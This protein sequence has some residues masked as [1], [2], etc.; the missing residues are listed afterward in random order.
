MRL[1]RGLARVWRAVHLSGLFWLNCIV[2]SVAI[3]EIRD[4]PSQL[5]NVIFITVI[6]IN[7]M[8]ANDVTNRLSLLAP[9]PLG[10]VVLQ[11]LHQ[12]LCYRTLRVGGRRMDGWIR[13]GHHVLWVP[14]PTWYPRALGPPALQTLQIVSLCIKPKNIAFFPSRRKQH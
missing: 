7:W 1:R 5:Y 6:L 12:Y 11:D 13:L 10:M 14:F 3:G 9:F 2:G 8:A 4:G